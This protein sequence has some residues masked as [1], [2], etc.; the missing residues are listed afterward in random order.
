MIELDDD[1]Q[2][3]ISID[4]GLREASLHLWRWH[5]DISLTAS[6]VA[7]AKMLGISKDDYIEAKKRI[8]IE[9]VSGW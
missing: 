8:L 5:S 3:V 9:P 1:C 7:V 6:E 2:A 4:D